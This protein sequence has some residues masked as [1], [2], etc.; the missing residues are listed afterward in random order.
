MLC[1]RLAGVREVLRPQ[2]AALKLVVCAHLIRVEV[3]LVLLQIAQKSKFFFTNR[4]HKD[5]PDSVKQKAVFR[6][7]RF[8]L[9]E[10]HAKFTFEGPLFSMNT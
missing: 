8:S 2:G 9:K 4:T 7:V 10:L 5:I 6:Q 1:V 3:S